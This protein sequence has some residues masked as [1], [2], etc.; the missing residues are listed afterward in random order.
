[1][2]VEST[3]NKIFN[4]TLSLQSRYE[5]LLALL[6]EANQ[7]YSALSSDHIA[8]LRID[9][10]EYPTR[11]QGIRGLDEKE[12]DFISSLDKLA[13]HYHRQI[14]LM[15][16]MDRHDTEAPILTALLNDVYDKFFD[17]ALPLEISASTLEERE[18]FLALNGIK[19]R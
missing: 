4:S 5:A 16:Y 7:R 6:H 18:V 8:Y 10:S 17:I 13:E 19:R 3:L 14:G 2:S 1:M 15:L 11:L 12:Q 9:L